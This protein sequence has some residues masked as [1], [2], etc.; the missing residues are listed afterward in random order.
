LIYHVLNRGAGRQALFHKVEDYA[1]F[2]RIHGAAKPVA[3]RGRSVETLL[4]GAIAPDQGRINC[5]AP[6]CH[7]SIRRYILPTSDYHVV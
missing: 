4:V 5:H 6:A 3:Q 7:Q 2:E 1:A